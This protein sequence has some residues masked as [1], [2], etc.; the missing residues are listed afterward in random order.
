MLK[1]KQICVGIISLAHQTKLSPSSGHNK[2]VIKQ[3]N[4]LWQ[5]QLRTIQ[6][7]M[8]NARNL[9]GCYY[10]NLSTCTF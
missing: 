5:T 7:D 1:M 10:E 8:D 2:T 3:A 4:T 6:Y 9:I